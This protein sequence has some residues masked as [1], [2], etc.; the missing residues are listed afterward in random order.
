MGSRSRREPKR[1]A[2]AFQISL[3]Y[4]NANSERYYENVLLVGLFWF[5]ICRFFVP[6]L[7]L[8][9]GNQNQ[10]QHNGGTARH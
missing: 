2:Y 4:K 9:G 6:F 8:P 5:L 1:F 10:R 7:L 3:T